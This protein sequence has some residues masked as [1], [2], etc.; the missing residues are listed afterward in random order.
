MLETASSMRL[1]EIDLIVLNL[2]W[3]PKPSTLSIADRHPPTLFN[4]FLTF[5][6]ISS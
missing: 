5:I 2:K 1:I 4:R 3:P 6:I